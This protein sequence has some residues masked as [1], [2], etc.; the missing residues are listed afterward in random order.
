MG[1]PPKD[2]IARRRA[3]ASTLVEHRVAVI[4]SIVFVWMRV[5]FILT[6]P[7]FETPD[8]SSYRSGQATRPPLSSMMLSTLGDTPYVAVSALLTST[9]FVAIAWALWDPIRRQRSYIMVALVAIVSLLPMVLVYEHWLVPDS[10][11]TGLALLAL[12]LAS[13]RLDAR[14][15]PWAVLALCTM[16]TLTKEVGIGIVVMVALVLAVRGSSRLAVTAALSSVLLFAIV[17]LPT[18]DRQGRVFWD[19]PL[20]TELTMGRARVIIAGMFWDDLSEELAEVHQR[21]TRCGMTSEQLIAETFRLTD[22]FVD[23]SRCAGLWDAVDD[24]SPIDLLTAHVR[25]PVHVGGAIQRGFTADM[26]SMA[27]WSA[28]PLDQQSLMN[29]DRVAAGALA[30]LPALALAIAAG[31]R[32]GL[33]FAVVAILGTMMGLAAALLDPSS[34]DRHTFVFR[35]AALAVALLALTDATHGPISTGESIEDDRDHADGD[36]A[37]PESTATN[38]RTT[39]IALHSAHA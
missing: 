36:E 26:G 23:Y 9:G 30:L 24:V 21:A 17:V 1:H 16:I 7:A 22:R 33:R 27:Y 2:A 34:Q 18:S 31:R 11:L 6:T 25:N 35:I 39:P 19:Q 5:G 32:R 10:L 29:A 14:W 3:F 37:T 15:Y 13:R 8:T 12:A 38:E 4:A 20:D 28:F